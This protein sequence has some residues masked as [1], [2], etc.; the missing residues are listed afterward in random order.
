MR[1][2]FFHDASAKTLDEA[3]DWHL[4]G[5]VGHNADPS[6]VEVKKVTLTAQERVQL[7]AFVR[8]LTDAMVPNMKPPLP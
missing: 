8:A 3:I 4:A 1:V 5:G 6:I 2:A 7:G